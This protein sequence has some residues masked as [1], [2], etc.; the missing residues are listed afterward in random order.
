MVMRIRLIEKSAYFFMPFLEPE[1]VGPAS[2]LPE[3]RP[4]IGGQ[5]ANCLFCDEGWE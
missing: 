5:A 3:R 1:P 2:F 4:F